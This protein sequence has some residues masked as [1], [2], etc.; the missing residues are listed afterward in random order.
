MV[1]SSIIINYDILRIKK[2]QSNNNNNNNQKLLRKDMSIN[3]VKMANGDN[4]KY[5]L[6]KKSRQDYRKWEK[7]KRRRSK[8]DY[9][10]RSSNNNN[11][12][13]KNRN[14]RSLN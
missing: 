8:R 14:N 4:I 13:N 10:N 2:W 7:V 6:M 11:S 3:Y 9:K 1:N 12:N 5:V